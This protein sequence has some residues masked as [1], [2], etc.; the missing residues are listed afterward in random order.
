MRISYANVTASL[1]LFVA[2]GGTDYAA[3][4]LP[5]N[6][7]GAREIKAGAVGTSEVR[8]G[9]LRAVDFRPGQLPAGPRGPQGE[10]GPQGVPGPAG[11]AG[12][13]DVSKFYDKAT[14][15]ARFAAGDAQVYA[16]SSMGAVGG[17]GAPEVTTLLEAPGLGTLTGRCTAGFKGVHSSNGGAW[18]LADHGGTILGNNTVAEHDVA[19]DDGDHVAIALSNAGALHADVWLSIIG[20]LCIWTVTGISSKPAA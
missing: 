12:Q 7:V 9:S 11:P 15:D 14:S 5:K 2:L 19:L 13:P 6:S 10:R 20:N 8:D 18:F 4:K 17:A 16:K 3:V 1:A